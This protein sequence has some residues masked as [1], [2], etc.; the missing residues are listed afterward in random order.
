MQVRVGS[1]YQSCCAVVKSMQ[2]CVYAIPSSPL[3]QVDE[4]MKLDKDLKE[5]RISPADVQ[6]KLHVGVSLVYKH[7][8]AYKSRIFSFFLSFATVDAF[9]YIIRKRLQN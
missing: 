7:D 4:M 6:K 9:F 2:R 5:S 3:L 1:S 8:Y